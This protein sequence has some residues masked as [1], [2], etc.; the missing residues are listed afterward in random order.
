MLNLPRLA[1]LNVTLT[2]VAPVISPRANLML[3]SAHEIDTRHFAAEKQKQHTS[4]NRRDK[5]KEQF[6]FVLPN[7]FNNYNVALNNALKATLGLDASHLY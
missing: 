5:K 3:I 6:K 2:I 7:I 4:T 1:S